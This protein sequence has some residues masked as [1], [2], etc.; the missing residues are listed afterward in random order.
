LKYKISSKINIKINFV[1]NTNM[2]ASTIFKC[3]H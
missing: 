1:P 2:N 3:T